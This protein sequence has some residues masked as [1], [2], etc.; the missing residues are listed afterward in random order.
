M[1]INFIFWLLIGLLIY[2]YFGYTIIV[3]IIS[4][5]K[6]FFSP[7]KGSE[8]HPSI[9]LLPDVTIVIA[10]YNEE[11]NI[12]E[13][14]QNTLQQDYPQDKIVQIWVNDS[15]SDRTK[16][17]LTQYSNI[18]LLNQPERQ[19]KVA[20]INFA[21]QYVKTPIT[22]FSDANAMLSA[23][24][25]KK[26][27]EPFSNS[28]VGCVAGEKRILMNAIENAAATGEGIY[29][30]YESFIKQIESTCGS[31]LSA[32]GELYA[33]RTELFEKVANDTI[34]DDFFISTHVVK[35]G[36]LVKYIPDAYACEK[37]SANINEEKKRKVRIAAG[38]FQALF[39]NLELLNPFKYPMFSFQFL[40]HKILRWFV[41]PIS[42]ILVPILNVLILLFSSQSPVYL[43]TL[44]LQAFIILMIIS[45]WLFKDKPVSSKWVFLPY[46]LFMM[47]ISIIQ[48][49]IRYITGKQNVKWDKSLRQS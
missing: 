17:L 39:R 8:K 16:D 49:F 12:D 44:L 9:D 45:G 22:I 33:I 48:G 24:A 20:A 14:V 43:A 6:R 41:L 5:A 7:R 35:K 42:L 34:L 38:S 29:W 30:K 13:K 18:I 40:S 37:A 47:N 23:N 3:L 25:I 28:K 32:T 31:A 15:S 11:K 19:G 36:Y 27:V 4:I 21:L 2:S 1:V 10:A 46:Y 26:I